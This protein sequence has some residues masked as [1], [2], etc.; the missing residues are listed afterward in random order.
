MSDKNE[1]LFV[2]QEP[3]VKFTDDK[4]G[5]RR[6]FLKRGGGATAGAFV[7]V[8][9]FEKIE[10][11]IVGDPYSA[12]FNPSWR[13]RFKTF[14]NVEKHS[15]G[16]SESWVYNSE[17]RWVAPRLNMVIEHDLDNSNEKIGLNKPKWAGE[18]TNAAKVSI[19]QSYAIFDSSIN[20]PQDQWREMNGTELGD[21]K[22]GFTPVSHEESASIT[23]EVAPSS[24][25]V[26]HVSETG[27]TNPSSTHLNLSIS[28]E[29]TSTYSA[30]ATLKVGWSEA[31]ARPIG[32]TYHNFEFPFEVQEKA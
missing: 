24:G 28:L 21:Y 10:G 16:T 7:S 17:T 31:G 14:E 12:S 2:P 32:W 9:L 6:K 26:L 22:P 1:K 23:K 5:S 29:W 19:E 11:A 13:I 25:T 15:T 20:P 27:S 18:A 4:G 3:E 8:Y 30:D